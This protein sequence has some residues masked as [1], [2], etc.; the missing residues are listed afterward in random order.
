MSVELTKYTPVKG[1]YV[2]VHTTGGGVY[3]AGR[4][5]ALSGGTVRV[6]IAGRTTT[7]R[8]PLTR[9]SRHPQNDRGQTEPV[10]SPEPTPTPQSGYTACACRDCMDTAVSGDTTKPELCGECADEGCNPYPPSDA[11]WRAW[12]VASGYECQRDDAYGE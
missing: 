3:A 10:T 7:V 5:T 1:D 8:V 2:F 12:P 11:D 6:R 9:V 4:V